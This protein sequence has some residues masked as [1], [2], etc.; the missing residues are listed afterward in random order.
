M[1]PE[2]LIKRNETLHYTFTVHEKGADQYALPKYL[3]VHITDDFGNLVPLD[4]LMFAYS[5]R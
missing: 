2:I 1:K 3:G 5:L 4:M